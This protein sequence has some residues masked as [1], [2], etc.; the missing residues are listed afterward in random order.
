[1]SMWLSRVPS[2]WAR[3][4]LL[5]AVGAL[6]A[7]VSCMGRDENS[8]GTAVPVAHDSVATAQHTPTAVRDLSYQ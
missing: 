8:V 7:T 5:L 4:K 1:M 2:L 3:A 6:V